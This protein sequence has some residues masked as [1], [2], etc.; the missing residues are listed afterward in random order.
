MASISA[1]HLLNHFQDTRYLWEAPTLTACEEALRLF[2]AIIARCCKSQSDSCQGCSHW[3][4]CLVSTHRDHGKR[5]R[6]SFA[7]CF[8]CPPSQ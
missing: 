6:N 8:A 1:W 2:L 3:T 4:F 5:M 7:L